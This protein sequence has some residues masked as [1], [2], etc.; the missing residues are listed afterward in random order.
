MDIA[1][2]RFSFDMNGIFS[3]ISF[4]FAASISAVAAYRYVSFSGTEFG[5]HFYSSSKYDMEQNTQF[6]LR[7]NLDAA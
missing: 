2:Y 1:E 3:S 5:W 6:K 7:F 4:D